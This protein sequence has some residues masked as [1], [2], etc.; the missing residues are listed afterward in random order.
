MFYY[1]P[2]QLEEVKLRIS[3]TALNA[4]RQANDIKLVAVSKT[5]PSEAILAAYNA[6]QRL[7]G[8]NRVQEMTD[9][10][11]TLPDDIQW[12]LIGHLQ[13]NKTGNAV[14][15]SNIIESVDSKKL[16][17]RLNRIAAESDK[18]QRILLEINISGE[19]SKFGETTSEA[20]FLLA[21]TAIQ[22]PNIKL[23]GLM[24]MAPWGV[25]DC[26]I[27][28]CFS[29]LRELRNNIEE[30]FAVKIPDLSMGMSSDYAIAI[31]EGA[32]ILR[33]GTAIFG[34]RD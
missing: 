17:L 25:D 15:L 26:E 33:I 4:G 21:E 20:A 32:T 14:K 11:P 24:T 9:K 3:Q 10:V 31:E 8:E 18:I 12:H 7:F 6:G 29:G 22:A 34:K 16:L 2:K 19:K 23:E 27:R 1:I 28:K 13:G 30:K 5:F